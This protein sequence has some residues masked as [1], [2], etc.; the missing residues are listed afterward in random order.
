MKLTEL[1]KH[2][3]LGDGVPDHNGEDRCVVCRLGRDQGRAKEAHEPVELAGDVQKV[4]ARI[5]G[6]ANDSA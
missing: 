1:T 6:E 5:V 2:D 3:Y 4:S